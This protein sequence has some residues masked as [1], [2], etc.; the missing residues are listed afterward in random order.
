MCLFALSAGL[1]AQRHS[2][3]YAGR[4][5]S[6][7]K[8]VLIAPV[9]GLLQMSSVATN[10]GTRGRHV[11]TWNVYPSA[12]IERSALRRTKS[13]NSAAVAAHRLHQPLGC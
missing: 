1:D 13:F 2:D 5:A 8:S 12:R 9:L 10:S 11:D 6:W 3:L 4:D 7:L